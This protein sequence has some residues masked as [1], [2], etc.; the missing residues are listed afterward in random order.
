MINTDQIKKTDKSP[1]YYQYYPRLFSAYYPKINTSFIEDLSKAGYIYYQSV[2]FTD[3]LIDD[4]DFSK[5]PYIQIYQEET[6]KILTSIYGRESIFW[7]YW[8]NRRNEYFEA[9]A[10][11]KGLYIKNEIDISV[12]ENLA[13]KKS[14]FGKVAI[15]CLHVLDNESGTDVYE[16]LITS[17]HYFSVGFQ[18]YDDIKDFKEDFTKDQFNWVV[19]ELSKKVNFKDYDNNV[20]ILNKLIYI[21]EIAQNILSRSIENFKKSISILET[22]NIESEW[23][24]I[25]RDMQKTIESYLDVTEGYIKTLE[26]KFEIK[27]SG[28]P[29]SG[30]FNYSSVEN[31]SIKKGLQY[32]ENDSKENFAELKHYMYLSEREDFNN[33]SQI[34][35]SDTFQR[36]M[37][38]DC[39]WDVTRNYNLDTQ[40]FFHAECDYLANRTNKDEVG[41]WAY[42]PTV[43]EIAADIDDLGQI[44]QLFI[45][46]NRP[47]L[48][49]NLCTKPILTALENRTDADGGIETWIIPRY[50]QTDIQKLQEYFNVT[51]WGKGPDVEVVANFV[52]ALQKLQ[53]DKYRDYIENSIKYILSH[54]HEKGY[55]ESRWYYGNYYGTYVCLRLLKEFGDVYKEDINEAIDY[56]INSQHD[57]GGFSVSPEASTDPLNTAF[58]LLSLKLCF[59][60]D[61]L[62]VK[63][64]ENYLINSQ[65]ESGF[66][67]E[68]DFIKPKAQ[69][70]YKSKTI[71]TAFAL[72]ALC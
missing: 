30:F 67:K 55:W 33:T 44:I 16:K 46:C 61:H 49:E 13:D 66:W 17:H 41:G 31:D 57:D 10:I 22:L 20:L 51:K 56:I 50:S 43:K 70:P 1:E 71:T 69:E 6:I 68:V 24:K 58:A 36:A 34:H 26:K 27:N 4:K 7:K 15:D 9:V 32:I 62:P 12:Y 42:F 54:Q 45:K 8:G 39:L 47:D 40:I 64:A 18:L 14:A 63:K 65:A 53:D 23:L 72:K 28:N 35:A 38:N 29:A 21:E 3:S 5:I 25:N 37:L 11:E 52:Y 48:I 19:Y 59:P 2:L 60:K